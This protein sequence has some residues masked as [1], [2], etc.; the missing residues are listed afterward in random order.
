[1]GGAGLPTTKL[2]GILPHFLERD[3]SFAGS[4]L[5][6]PCPQRLL[7]SA[8]GEQKQKGTPS[9]GELAVPTS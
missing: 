7:A 4:S 8:L 2:L 9:L 1:M 5:L 6:S 3:F